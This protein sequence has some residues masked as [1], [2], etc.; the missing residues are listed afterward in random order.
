VRNLSIRRD[1]K[2]G[3]IQVKLWAEIPEE[4]RWTEARFQ[5]LRDDQPELSSWVDRQIHRLRYPECPVAIRYW[6]DALWTPCGVRPPETGQ[7]CARHAALMGLPKTP[8]KQTVIVRLT[9][10]E[11]A[12]L[13]RQYE[14][15]AYRAI[16]EIIRHSMSK[17]V[18]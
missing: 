6:R 4:D 13:E 16:V 18:R 7:P 9:T 3:A 5:R 11:I 8:A 10:A 14:R 2:T 1:K 12:W 15:P 17:N